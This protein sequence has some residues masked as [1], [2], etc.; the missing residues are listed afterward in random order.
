[1]SMFANYDAT[2]KRSCP[3]CYWAL[4]NNG[5]TRCVCNATLEHVVVCHEATQQ[6]LI[7]K[8]YCMSFPYTIN[9]TVIGR[10]PFNYQHPDTQDFYVTLPN[11]TKQLHV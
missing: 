1:M 11:D 3:T 6:T 10:C 2:E 4:K 8:S 9:D 5:V 7:L